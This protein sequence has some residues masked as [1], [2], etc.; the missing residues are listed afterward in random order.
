MDKF[1]YLKRLC[2]PNEW[3]AWGMYPDDLWSMYKDGYRPEHDNSPEHDRNGAFHW[4]LARSPSGA[5][6]RRLV[7]L[8]FLDP[9]QI[10][11]SDVRIYLRR[12]IERIGD[13][14]GIAILDAGESKL[15]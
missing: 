12:A 11:A 15:S 14:E 5:D 13:D 3:L 9:D 8:S 7:R 1:E 10:M 2:F 6:L 4:W